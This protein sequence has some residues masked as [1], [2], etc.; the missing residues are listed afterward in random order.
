MLKILLLDKF[1]IRN[2][3]SLV[4]TSFEGLIPRNDIPQERQNHFAD[5]MTT[6]ISLGL[7]EILNH[8]DDFIENI[9]FSLLDIVH[10]L[11]KFFLLR[12]VDN[13]P[14]TIF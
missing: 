13:K 7:V 11:P 1:F 4:H 6:L 10:K 12:T 8:G 9:R 2:L 5:I 14:I 3:K